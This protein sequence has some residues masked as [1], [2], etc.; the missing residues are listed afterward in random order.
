MITFTVNGRRREVD[1]ESD[2][3]LLWVLREVLDLT[4]TKY[5]CGIAECGACTVHVEGEPM[6]SCVLPVSAVAGKR[7]ATIEGLARRGRLHPVK[8]RACAG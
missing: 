6:R 8:C 3:P 2:M 7:V 4:G 1:V 5:G